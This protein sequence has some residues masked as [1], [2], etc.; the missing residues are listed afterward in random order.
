MKKQFKEKKS[1]S[2]PNTS[3]RNKIVLVFLFAASTSLILLPLF[4]KVQFQHFKSLGIFGI[5]LINFI[6]SA[7]ILLPTPGILSVGVGANLYNPL[8]VVLAATLGSTIGEGTTFL[9]GFSSAEILK[10]KERKK[11]FEF[12]RYLLTRWGFIIIPIFSFI[13]NPFFDGLGIVAGL[14]KYP[15]KRYLF[16]TFVGR[17]A[18]NIVIAYIGFKI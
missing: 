12:L 10:V 3:T 14:I 4:F 16:L 2:S 5:F 11:L 8:L 7:T 17:L 15:I 13:P 9:F 6:S 1:I 18:R